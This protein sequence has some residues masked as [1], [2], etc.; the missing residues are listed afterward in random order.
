[1]NSKLMSVP[2]GK[3]LLQ[4]AQSFK[5][6]DDE[7][8]TEIDQVTFRQGMSN[9][10][11]AVNVITTDGAAG[12]AGWQPGTAPGRAAGTAG[13]CFHRSDRAD[14]LDS[15]KACTPDSAGSAPPGS[16]GRRRSPSR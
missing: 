2:S 8:D 4:H 11:A 12:Q 14:R 13:C 15:R 6:A 10:G 9:L 1:M 5:M 3:D 7:A 16:A